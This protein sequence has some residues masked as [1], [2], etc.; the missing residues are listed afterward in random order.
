M[1]IQRLTHPS[2]L[3]GPAVGQSLR[4][5]RTTVRRSVGSLGVIASF[6][7]PLIWLVGWIVL[8]ATAVKTGRWF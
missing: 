2:L 3:I 8:L 1:T 4:L 5:I 7:S 6:I